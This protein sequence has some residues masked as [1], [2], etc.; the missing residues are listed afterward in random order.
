[1]FLTVSPFTAR[2]TVMPKLRVQTECRQNASSFE[3][4][5]TFVD[6]FVCQFVN[7]FRAEF[8]DVERRHHRTVDHRPAQHVFVNRF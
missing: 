5:E 7:T 4:L 6:F 8:F 1:M 3:T 2:Y